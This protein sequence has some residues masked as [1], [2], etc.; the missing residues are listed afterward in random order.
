MGFDEETEALAV[1]LHIRFEDGHLMV[2]S[3]CAIDPAAL[4]RIEAVI[5]HAWRFVK[6][7]D[8]RWLS[9]GEASRAI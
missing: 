2:G 6:F 8:S 9:L 7:C 1:G 3:K 5:F 4:S